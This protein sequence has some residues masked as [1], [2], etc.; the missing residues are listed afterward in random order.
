MAVDN[1]PLA[2]I[3]ENI[4][5]PCSDGTASEELTPQFSAQ[6]KQL[7]AAYFESLVSYLHAR[8]GLGPPEPED[9]AQQAF[10]KLANRGHLD[11]VENSKAFLWRTAHNAMLSGK[12]SEKVRH[13]YDSALYTQTRENRGGELAADNVLESS[14]QLNIIELAL[15]RMPE[16]RRRVFILHRFEGLNYTE[17][18]KR[19]G[20]GRTA[21]TK[22]IARATADI[23]AALK[24]GM[25]LEGNNA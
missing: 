16:K 12:R 25:P 7:Y 1:K 9:I 22:H 23:E 20:I 19:L 18:G 8:F 15:K 11:D 17:V 13:A 3:S 6:L 5:V 21:V 10:A 14:Q 2:D 24:R 4:E